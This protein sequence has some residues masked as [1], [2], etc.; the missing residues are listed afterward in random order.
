MTGFDLSVAAAV[1]RFTEAFNYDVVHNGL[2]ITAVVVNHDDR[3]IEL[4][5]E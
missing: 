1:L 4:V 5:T 2:I 3:T